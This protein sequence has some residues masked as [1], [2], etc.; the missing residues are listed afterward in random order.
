MTPKGYTIMDSSPS[1][2]TSLFWQL[3]IPLHSGSQ[4]ENKKITLKWFPTAKFFYKGS[5]STRLQDKGRRRKETPC[6]SQMV[7]EPIE[8]RNHMS[9]DRGGSR[10][11]CR[12]QFLP[13]THIFLLPT[14]LS[15]SASFGSFRPNSVQSA[16]AGKKLSTIIGFFLT[17]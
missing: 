4:M 5:S 3:I 12:K 10:Q 6:T 9:L 17:I 13:H 8:M 16:D 7:G 1:Q 2:A 15:A 11:A 14:A